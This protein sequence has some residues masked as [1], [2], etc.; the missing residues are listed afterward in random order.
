MEKKNT[1]IVYGFVTGFTM[2]IFGLIL[3]LTGLSFRPDMKYV[4][5]L[6]MLPFIIGIVMNGIAFSKANDGFVTF[7]NVFGSCFKASMIVTIV[8]VG[9]GIISMIIFPE[10]KEKAL[11]MAH[12]NMVKQKMTDEQI[13]T[14]INISKKYWNVIMIAGGIFGNLFWG[15]L[16][17]IIGAGVAKKKGAQPFPSDSF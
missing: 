11:E 13:D 16:F 2:V 3:Y 12:D 8:A 1:H 17:S 14:A 15:A 10:M 7:G 4:T 5:Y 9:W 6:S